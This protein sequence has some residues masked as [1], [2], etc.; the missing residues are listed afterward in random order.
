MNRN[1]LD[2]KRLGPC[3]AEIYTM[4]K[5]PTTECYPQS[6]E[7]WRDRGVF[8]FY[9]GEGNPPLTVI[10]MDCYYISETDLKRIVEKWS[11]GLHGCW[12][13][14]PKLT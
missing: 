6:F 8:A 9:N 11:K 3:V 2:K 14:I 7:T 12:Y 4:A 10:P 1:D 5:G 13:Y